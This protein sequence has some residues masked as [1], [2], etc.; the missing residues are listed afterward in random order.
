[1]RT[2]GARSKLVGG[3]VAEFLNPPYGP[4]FFLFACSEPQWTV[5]FTGLRTGFEK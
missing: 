1:M 5:A 2:R 4:S 3:F